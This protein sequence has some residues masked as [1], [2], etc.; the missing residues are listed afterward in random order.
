[1]LRR[2]GT[3]ETLRLGPASKDSACVYQAW[4]PA[5]SWFGAK[6]SI[7]SYSLV[8]CT[9]APGFEF[10]EFELAD[11]VA[12][13]TAFPQHRVVIEQLAKVR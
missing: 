1:V 8:G 10:S 13:V 2:D 9:V 3:Q 12:L 11:P 5:L 7:N 4:V 6:V